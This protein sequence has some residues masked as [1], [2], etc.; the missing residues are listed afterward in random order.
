MNNAQ[1]WIPLI[2]VIVVPL[3]QALNHALQT[4]TLPAIPWLAWTPKSRAVVALLLA[5][6]TTVIVAAATGATTWAAWGT[7]IAVGLGSQVTVLVGKLLAILM[8]PA[9]PEQ[10]AARRSS[11]PPVGLACLTFLGVALLLG[12][13]AGSFE[14]SKA[15]GRSLRPMAAP[16][17]PPS[18]YCLHV[19]NAHRDWTSAA[20]L[21]GSLAGVS[22]IAAIPIK[23][24]TIKTV[25]IGTAVGAAA[26]DAFAGIEGDSYGQA[27]ARDCAVAQ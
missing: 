16:A 23:D 20:A 8:P 18:A 7:A 14:T 19:D 25:A 24:D 1:L 26:F 10:M 22:G 12:G 27:W 9:T 21:S 6:V 17:V 2:L 5:T 13:C 15:A 3:S 11:R 4:N